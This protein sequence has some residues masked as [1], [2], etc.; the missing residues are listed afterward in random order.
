MEKITKSSDE[1]AFALADR[2]VESLLLKKKRDQDIAGIIG[3]AYFN[4]ERLVRQLI[5][6]P[7]GNERLGTKDKELVSAMADAAAA[8]KILSDRTDDLTQK[9]GKLSSD[10]MQYGDESDNFLTEI[11]S[12]EDSLKVEVANIDSR[13]ASERSAIETLRELEGDLGRAVGKAEEKC[14]VSF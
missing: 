3:E 1:K 11:Q 13:M 2:I 9:F 7:N 12:Y 5:L 8:F 10:Q 4:L 14:H 6:V